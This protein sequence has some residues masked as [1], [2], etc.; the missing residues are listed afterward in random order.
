MK[1]ALVFLV[2]IGL[3]VLGLPFSIEG[4]SS[5]TGAVQSFMAYGFSATALLLGMVTIF[6]S[7]SL[8]DEVS[9]RQIFL[10]MTKPV[11]RWQYIV[12]KWLGITLLNASFLI[13]TTLT[14]YGMVRYIQRTHPP[15]DPTYDA[16]ALKNEVLVARHAI[17]TKLPN[18]A[19]EAEAELERNVEDGLYDNVPNFDPEAEKDR[20]S[21][22]HEAKWRIV[23]PQEARLFE[24]ENI[25]VDRSPKSLVYLRY[26]A[27]VTGYPP[28]EIYRS[29][30]LFGNRFKGTPEY[31]VGT[32]H[33]VGR[34]H[35][36][37]IPADAVAE[38]H[39]L[40]VRFINQ[41]PHP[42]EPQFRNVIEFRKADEVELLF[43]VGSFE[44]NLFRLA[45]LMFCKL[46]FL[47][48]V[49]ILMTTCFSF[50][51][52]ALA[53]FT[54]YVL[55]GARGFIMDSIDF[56]SAD[57][58]NMLSSPKEF[59]LNSIAAVYGALGWVIPDFARFD[60]VD[61]LVNG[62]NVSLV[63]VLQ[64]ISELGLI[65]TSIALGLAVLLFY[66]RE[67]AEVSM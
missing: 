62:R 56:S 22:K 7:R 24:F 17:E 59:A 61:D 35:N 16:A 21:K 64:G 33:M 5:L 15:I 14:I 53:S 11:A 23:G 26:K 6:L 31:E 28:D 45:I 51:V 41:N 47:A 66:R 3:V 42:A 49:A 8:S 12:G 39:T 46:M 30:W 18:F 1:I 50:P 52:A 48:A 60:A 2:L 40:T 20:L 58:A 38:D 67:L 36:I 54:V 32:R 25:L 63:W 13:C 43:I 10:V 19:R 29:R 37:L 55:A 4:D 57:Y 65:K 9:N 27:E 34:Y 44:G